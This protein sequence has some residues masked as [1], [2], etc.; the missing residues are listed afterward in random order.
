[1]KLPVPDAVIVTE[2][3]PHLV[4]PVELATIGEETMILVGV[5]VAE[6]TPHE[7]VT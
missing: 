4:A 3:L 5:E 1:L 2:P 7:A 6:F